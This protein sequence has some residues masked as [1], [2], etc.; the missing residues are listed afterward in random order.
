MFSGGFTAAS[1]ILLFV[2]IMLPLFYVVFYVFKKNF[3]FILMLIGIVASFLLGY[4]L[5]VVLTG[6]FAPARIIGVVSAAS[7]A[8]RY[9]LIVGIVKALGM[10]LVL[11]LLSKRYVTVIVP[12]S[13][14]AGYSLI[15][16]FRYGA[17]GYAAFSVASAVNQNGLDYVV[18]T[19]D[20]ASQAGLREYL[21][22][23]AQKPASLYVWGTADAV[24]G[25]VAT[26]CLARLLWYSIE[27]GIREE[28]KK[29]VPIVLIAAVL[30]ELPG[31][32]YDGGAFAGYAP[33]GIIYYLLTAL[34][35]LGTIFAARNHDEKTTVAASRL[36]RRGR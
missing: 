9:S 32:L 14:A 28:N 5:T 26:I 1:F 8:I 7:Y 23:L 27:G 13:F 29:L 2:C 31:A 25:F 16:I 35:V 10:W 34:L 30:L 24:C 11:L 4:L 12:A 22:D 6:L 3:N 33:A 18:S 20:L 15:D 17:H 21:L 36:R 19:A